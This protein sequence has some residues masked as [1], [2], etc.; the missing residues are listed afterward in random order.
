[1]KRV[2]VVEDNKDNRDLLCLILE[3]S[4]LEVAVAPCGEEAVRMALEDT[5]HL[6]V[7]DIQ[8]PDI[9]GLEVTRRIRAGLA[10]RRVP[11]VVV[12]SYAMPADRAEAT[13]AGCDG[14]I[15]KP[16]D[17]ATI[18]EELSRFL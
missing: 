13:E 4:G 3:K 17:T 7:M 6:I 2:L 15:E 8:L 9:D 16:I 12:S 1:M 14:Y 10:D 18:V 11:I 5:P